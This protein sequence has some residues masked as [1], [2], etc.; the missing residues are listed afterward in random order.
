MFWKLSNVTSYM[1]IF[2]FCPNTI[3]LVHKQNL[4]DKSDEED[5]IGYESDLSTKN[6]DIE[7]NT[8]TSNWSATDKKKLQHM[9]GF[10][11]EYQHVFGEGASI[12]TIMKR[13]ISHMNPPL[14]KT[15]LKK[16]C[17]M[18]S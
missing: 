1:Y 16:K 6:M 18:P 9:T 14:P 7:I 11:T 15:I 8:D 4:I 10:H 3:S 2:S 12:R 13:R 17:R 5:E